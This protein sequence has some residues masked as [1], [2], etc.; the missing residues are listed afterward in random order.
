MK[1]S[2]LKLYDSKRSLIISA[3]PFRPRICVEINKIEP[4]VIELYD[5]L[6]SNL[7]KY[8][9]EKLICNL[10]ISLSKLFLF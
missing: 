6:M 1:G 3:H 2:E 8:F 10:L 4:S 7:D 5:I 9:F